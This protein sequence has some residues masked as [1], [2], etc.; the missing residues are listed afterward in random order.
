MK[1][2]AL[3][4]VL[5]VSMLILV[6]G[7][8]ASVNGSLEDSRVTIEKDKADELELELDIGAGE[9]NVDGD[10]NEWVEGTI[11]FNDKKLE[12]EV[13]Y[14]LRGNKGI[15][16]I[17]QDDGFFDN[18]NFRD[19][20]N[21]W[22]LKLNKEIPTE[23]IINSGAAKSNLDLK[24]LNLS[25]LEV[26]AGV[27]D[28]TIDLGGKWEQSFDASLNMGVGNSKVILPKDVG[29]KIKSSNGIGHTDFV[30]FISE[31]DG[32][33]VNEAYKDAD[34]II[35]LSTELGVGEATFQLE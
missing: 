17:K 16:V 27:G 18:M 4:S 19:F 8:G 22:D 26:N 7:C 14:K 15:G 28:M 5:T 11:E 34:V 12:T 9:L 29:V 31:G 10:A 6:A 25:N 1:K 20:K 2:N 3:F 13:S 21:N 32:I 33:Y 35:N 24:G 23:L 30:D